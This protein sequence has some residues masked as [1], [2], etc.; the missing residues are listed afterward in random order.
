MRCAATRLAEPFGMVRVAAASVLLAGATI[1]AEAQAATGSPPHLVGC[2]HATATGDG[3][4][5]VSL[6]TGD[7][8][9]L[10]EDTLVASIMRQLGIDRAT[11]EFNG[12]PQQKFAVVEQFLEGEPARYVVRYPLEAGEEYLAPI[13]HELAHVLQ[14]QST[15]GFEATLKAVQWQNRRVELGADYL[16][17]L[18]FSQLQP[19]SPRFNTAQFQHSL[20]LIGLYDERELE[21]HGSPEERTAAFRYGFVNNDGQTQLLPAYDYFQANLFAQIHHEKTSVADKHPGAGPTTTTAG[22]E[23]DKLTACSD[24]ETLFGRLRRGEIRRNCADEDDYLMREIVSDSSRNSAGGICILANPPAPFLDGFHCFL[25]PAAEGSDIVCFREADAAA[26]AQYK[27]DYKDVF[28]A[29]ALNYLEKASH[30]SL[31]NGDAAASQS[32]LMPPY[33]MLVAKFDFGFITNLDGAKPPNSFIQHGYATVNPDIGGDV[34]AIEFVQILADVP[35]PKA[36][37][38]AHRVGDWTVEVDE[39]DEFDAEFNKSL[40]KAGAPA[41]FDGRGFDLERRSSGAV[42]Q[43]EKV[44][45]LQSV[46]NAVGTAME[47]E[48]F[49]EFDID[50]DEELSAKFSKMMQDV[51]N[52]KPY[53]LDESLAPR[54]PK[55]KVLM[56]YDRRFCGS[57]DRDDGKLIVFLMAVEPH[58][59]IE[60]EF[61]SVA[62]YVAAFGSCWSSSNRLKTYVD[63]LL[64]V[65]SDSVLSELENP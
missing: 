13:T 58:D 17:G 46:M 25:P 3:K 7:P 39:L 64:D 34:A 56:K 35:V 5:P 57:Y 1:A 48:G 19:T 23:L 33:L 18:V 42:P 51:T 14:M 47:D 52:R 54:N 20:S 6:C 61:G 28:A 30:C 29:P 15:G 60:K 11:V 16:T 27:K 2:F 36:N 12:C 32:S 62:A 4:V 9:K 10:G 55:V 40:R 26:V 38:I 21:A 63:G 49:E 53:G 45:L 50:E 37:G 41:A 22:I 24:I 44:R 8:L 31:S 65:A 43:P 59:G